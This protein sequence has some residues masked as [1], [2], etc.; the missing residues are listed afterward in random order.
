V[1]VLLVFAGGAVGAPARYLLDRWMQARHQVRFPIGTLTVNVLG[2][3]FL[4]WLS[5]SAGLPSWAAALLGT[6]FCGGFTTYSTFTVEA[7]QLASQGRLRGAASA[8]LYIALSL[9]LGLSAA[10][11][12]STL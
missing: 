2:C 11:V 10:T 7:V 5:A 9:L 8:G 12:G 4:G 3:F 1:T 6:G